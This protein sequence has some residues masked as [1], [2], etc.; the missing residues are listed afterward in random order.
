MG[1]SLGERQSK[2]D[3]VFDGCDF[4]TRFEKT[5]IVILYHDGRCRNGQ[6]EK[7]RLRQRW[8]GNQIHRTFATRHVNHVLSSQI[9]PSSLKSP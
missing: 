1:L 7:K 4:E 6:T 2:N 5:C 9:P 8:S 3:V